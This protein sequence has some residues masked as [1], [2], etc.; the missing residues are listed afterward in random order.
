MERP[1]V[2]GSEV[3]ARHIYFPKVMRLILYIMLSME[4]LYNI[5]KEVSLL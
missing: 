1:N 4:D 3:Y 2:G 5:T